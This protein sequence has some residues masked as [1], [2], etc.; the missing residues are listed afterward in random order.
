MFLIEP[1]YSSFIIIK[2]TKTLGKKI[3]KQLKNSCYRSS[4]QTQWKADGLGSNLLVFPGCVDNKTNLAVHGETFLIAS[5]KQAG[6]GMTLGGEDSRDLCP[7]FPEQR[8]GQVFSAFFL[9]PSSTSDL[10]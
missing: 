6:P 7:H 2:K 9:G 10:C 5:G 3:Q 4:K 1:L 8:K